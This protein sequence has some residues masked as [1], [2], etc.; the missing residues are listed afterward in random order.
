MH[1]VGDREHAWIKHHQD[2]YI[3][4]MKE[5]YNV[6]GSR[7][8]T[9]LLAHFKLVKT[10]EEAVERVE[11]HRFQSLIGALLYAG[12]HTRPDIAYAVRQLAHVVKN[13]TE[14]QVDAVGISSLTSQHYHMTCVGY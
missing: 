10:P 9:P 11:Q 12:V 3:G 6:G 14:E 5:R 2:K 13:P 7:V 8:T 4:Q 1:I